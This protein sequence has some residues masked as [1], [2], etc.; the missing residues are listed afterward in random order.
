MKDLQTVSQIWCGVMNFLML[1]EKKH[2]TLLPVM[3][4]FVVSLIDLRANSDK[5]KKKK[6][7]GMVHVH[8]RQLLQEIKNVMAVSLKSIYGIFNWYKEP[9]ALQFYSTH[10]DLYGWQASWQWIFI[11]YNQHVWIFQSEVA[12]ELLFSYSATMQPFGNTLSNFWV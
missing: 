10:K 2:I 6:K 9:V 12:L 11:E 4:M 1:Q 7:K 5:K 8:T 3:L